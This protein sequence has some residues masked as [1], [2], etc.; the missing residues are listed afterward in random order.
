MYSS[1]IH[2]FRLLGHRYFTAA[3]DGAITK[4]IHEK[5]PNLFQVITHDYTL[6]TSTQCWQVINGYRH[7]GVGTKVTRDIYKFPDTYWIIT[8]LGIL[9]M[10]SSL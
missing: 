2:R 7:F 5:K 3:A 1:S 8:R 4:T 6:N 9:T 10:L